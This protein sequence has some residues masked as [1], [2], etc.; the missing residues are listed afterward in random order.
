MINEEGKELKAETEKPY[1]FVLKEKLQEMR[2]DIKSFDDLTAFLKYVQDNCNSDYG[3]APRAIAQASVAVAWYLS[4]SFGITGFQAGCVM[5]DFIKDWEFT[6][7]KCGLYILDYDKMLF[8]Q[9]GPKFRGHEISTRTWEALQKRAKE[10]LEEQETAGENVIKAHSAVIAH[11]NS[12][13]AGNIPFGC[14]IEGNTE[15]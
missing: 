10:L 9:Y 5:W 6:N 11:W 7:N 12:I 2:K 15:C 13:A 8:P 14:T 1:E 3:G 4:S